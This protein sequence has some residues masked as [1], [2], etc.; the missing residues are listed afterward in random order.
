MVYAM[1]SI[2]LLG[3]L[4]WSHQMAFHLCEEMVINLTI[5]WEGRNLLYTFYSLNYNKYAQSAGNNIDGTSETTRENTYDLFIKKYY[6][7]KQIKFSLKPPLY[8]GGVR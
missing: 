1:A 3:F 8:R 2:G 7:F 4:V 6:D 5:C